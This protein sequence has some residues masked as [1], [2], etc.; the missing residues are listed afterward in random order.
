MRYGWLV[1]IAMVGLISG[2]A[3][4]TYQYGLTAESTVSD[5]PCECEFE[6]P[7]S[8]GGDHPFVDRIEK[9]V[10]S[11]RRLITR[12]RSG[13]EQSGEATASQAGET[14][15][16]TAVDVST[17]Y[18]RSNGLDDVH[19]DVRRYEPREQWRRL[20]QNDR[21]SPVWKYTAGSLSVL[22]YTVLPRRA[23]RIDSYSPYTN[24]LSLNSN[25]EANAIFAA[26]EAKAYRDQRLPG[27]YA[28]LQKA[29]IFP[30]AH[31]AKVSSDVLSYIHANEDWQLADEV[32]PRAY[33]KIASSAVSE[34][35]FFVPLPADL[36]P[37]T[38]PLTRVAGISLGRATGK[39]VAEKQ[40]DKRSD[41]KAEPVVDPG[42]AADNSKI[43]DGF[44]G[45]SD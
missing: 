39:W 36:P 21:I 11:P 40:R 23:F 33:S 9:F 28:V 32:Y 18:L 26:A 25:R 38:A 12:I 22:S 16:Q 45:T 2:C 42:R 1:W 14:S 7:I 30:L 43:A 35:L 37:V 17:A 24:T 41:K 31:T 13:N 15:F 44:T 34:A 19:I 27:V 20:Q 4:P 10:Q 29:P 5:I 3:R 8:I 6:N